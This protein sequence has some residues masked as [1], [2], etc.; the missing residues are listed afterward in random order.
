MEA[1]KEEV[2]CLWSS[3][4]IDSSIKRVVLLIHVFLVF[5]WVHTGDKCF[6]CLK[7]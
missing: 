5:L 6:Y 4:I 3:S 1:S 2:E 7:V